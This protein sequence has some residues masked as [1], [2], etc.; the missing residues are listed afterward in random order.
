MN[1][2][3]LLASSSGA[4][5]I[6]MMIVMP[7]MFAMIAFI[8]WVMG[9]NRH[10]RETMKIQNEMQIKLLDK[11]GSAQEL[12]NYL[13]S[14]AGQKFLSSATIEQTKPYGRI[15][16]GITAGIVIL[17]VGG[18]LLLFLLTF[19]LYAVWAEE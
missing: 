14:E 1:N 17:L 10:R 9:N 13:N 15:L 11:F 12:A 3:V 7:G 19:V 8:V 6:A 5:D 18:S 4:D 16:G 2:V